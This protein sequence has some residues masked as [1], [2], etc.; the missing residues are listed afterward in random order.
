MV[1]YVIVSSASVS[2]IDALASL[3]GKVRKEIEKGFRI[4][5]AIVLHFDPLYQKNIACQTLIK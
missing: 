2:A 4:N 1:N 5:G 3:E